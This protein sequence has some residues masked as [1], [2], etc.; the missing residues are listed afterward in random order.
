MEPYLDIKLLKNY[1][2][3]ISNSDELL[4]GA[5]K[6]DYKYYD[7]IIKFPKM[8]YNQLLEVCSFYNC[9]FILSK[10]FKNSYSTYCDVEN[11]INIVPYSKDN[12]LTIDQMVYLFSH[13]LSH[14]IQHIVAIDFGMEDKIKFGK[15]N[16]FSQV[17]SYERIAERLAYFIYKS[18]FKHLGRVHHRKFN[19]YNN[20]EDKKWLLGYL[21]QYDIIEDIKL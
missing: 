7:G 12:I 16:T 18:Y 4:V 19:T 17:L 20:K 9:R 10:W 1:I 21:K 2:I 6:S 15:L 13:E 11:L 5:Y 8:Y 14:R 3:S